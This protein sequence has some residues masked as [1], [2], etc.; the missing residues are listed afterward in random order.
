MASVWE[1]LKRRNVVRVA[2][3]G[4]PPSTILLARTITLRIGLLK[5]LDKSGHIRL[6]HVKSKISKSNFVTKVLTRLELQAE[7]FLFGITERPALT[8]KTHPAA[9]FSEQISTRMFPS[10]CII[11]RILVVLLAF[12]LLHFSAQI[13]PTSPV[14]YSQQSSESIVE[15]RSKFGQVIDTEVSTK[16]CTE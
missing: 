7:G 1:E 2:K 6:E 12:I 16:F 10:S 15:I 13:S 11:A 3:V 14:S 8:D 5:D 4:Y 9:H